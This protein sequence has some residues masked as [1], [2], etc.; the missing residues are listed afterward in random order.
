MLDLSISMYNFTIC[1]CVDVMDVSFKYLPTA[2]IPANIMT[3]ALPQLKH[4][5]FT[6]LLDLGPRL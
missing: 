4:N 6:H 1:E 5:T 3:K 2:A